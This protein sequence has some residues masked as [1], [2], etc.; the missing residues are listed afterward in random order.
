MPNETSPTYLRLGYG[1]S[2]GRDTY[3]YT[4]VRLTDESTGKTYRCMGGGYDMVG[5]VLAD[6]ATDVHQDR[7]IPLA[8][9]AYYAYPAE[10]PVT[11]SDAADALYGMYRY[12]ASA[13]GVDPVR[14]ALDGG[15]GQSSIERI[16]TAAGIRLTRTFK[17]AGR[18]RGATTGWLV[19]VGG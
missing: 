11:V 4:T 10:G 6:W 19:E 3:G 7:L 12:A 5:T 8:D 2:R 16:L 13:D 14:V 9:R 18:N 15:C 1:T 17:T